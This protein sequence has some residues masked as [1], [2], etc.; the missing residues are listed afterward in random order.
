MA[1]SPMS[2]TRGNVRMN[3]SASADSP[4]AYSLNEGHCDVPIAYALTPAGM[5]AA[6]HA[7]AGPASGR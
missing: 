3:S 6:T 1:V 5:W 2:Y 4:I 7:A